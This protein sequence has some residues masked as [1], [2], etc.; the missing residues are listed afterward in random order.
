MTK[1]MVARARRVLFMGVC[2]SALLVQV[3]SGAPTLQQATG[4]FDHKA[5]VTIAGSG[6]GTKSSAGPVVWDDASGSNINDKWSLTWPNS[7]TTYNIA[8]RNPQR[9]ISLP[10]NNITRY[11]A[12]AH[13]DTGNAGNGANVAVWKSRTI[14]SYPA[15]T[16]ASW[17]QRTDDAWVFGGDDNYKCFDF[18]KGSGGYDLPNN[19]YLEY[20][21]RPTSRSSGASWHL[22]DDA[23]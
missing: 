19:W 8:Y 7:N 12:G 2:V 6:F 11:I 9:G 22:L 18:T 16:Y 13:G 23:L 5:S 4:K 20:N 1:V 21:P 3:A 15:Y 10:H 17:Y 14:S